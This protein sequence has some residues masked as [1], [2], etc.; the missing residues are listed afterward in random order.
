MN[1]TLMFE[2]HADL[3]IS[4]NDRLHW[5]DEA[6]RTKSLRQLGH[7][8]A[9]NQRVVDMSPCHV[10]AFIGFTR[11]GTADPA[12]ANPTVKALLDGITDAGAWPDDDHVHVIGPTFLRDPKSTRPKH[13]TVRLVLTPQDI[14]WL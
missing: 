9:R 8:T 14:P 6:K 11:N 3:W 7:V 2:V 12:N 4:A 10:A 5:G 13:Y 1:T